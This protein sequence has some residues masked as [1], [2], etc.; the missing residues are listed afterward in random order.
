MEMLSWVLIVIGVAVLL[1]LFLL[2][3]GTG[4]KKRKKN[5]YIEDIHDKTGQRI[6]SIQVDIPAGGLT[7]DQHPRPNDPVEVVKV[8]QRE[9]QRNNTKYPMNQQNDDSQQDIF[10][11]D[12]SEELLKEEQQAARNQEPVRLSED[13][14]QETSVKSM[15]NIESDL[16][17]DQNSSVKK[18]SQ[19]MN[20]TSNNDSE[21]VIEQ[22]EQPISLFIASREKNGIP[23]I[24]LLQAL[25]S[26][27]LEF[28]DM[29]IYHRML[30]SE[31]GKIC[32]YSVANGVK[33]WT[34]KPDDVKQQSTPGISLVMQLPSPIDSVE[35]MEFFLASARILADELEADLLNGSHQPI[36]NDD[37]Q[38]LLQLAAQYCVAA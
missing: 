2:N 13:K 34:L 28:G 6:S 25:D 36:T 14:K 32:L 7:E 27:G 19:A 3:I 15:E 22:E 35:A 24:K 16:D 10:A 33:P 17:K 5:T 23:G 4:E 11:Q 8:K 31:Q 12:W 29:N 9:P 18:S 30:S 26:S 21:S 1:I 38:R 20:K 37:R